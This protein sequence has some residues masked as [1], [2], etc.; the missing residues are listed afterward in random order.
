MT[1][2]GFFVLKQLFQRAMSCTSVVSKIGEVYDHLMTNKILTLTSYNFLSQLQFRI[3][4][5]RA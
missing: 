4:G 1:H 5:T 2:F 3:W